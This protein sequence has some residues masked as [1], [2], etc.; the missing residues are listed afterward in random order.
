[1][2]EKRSSTKSAGPWGGSTKPPRK[3]RRW[4]RWLI[5]FGVLVLMGAG[6]VFG[7]YTYV[8]RK[9]GKDVPDITWAQSYRPPIVSNVISGDDQLLAEFYKERRRVIPYERIPKKLVQAF[10]A[11]E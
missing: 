5:A 6:A 9:Y 7:T 11:A 2:A 1:M 8:M 10:V 3:R 4:S